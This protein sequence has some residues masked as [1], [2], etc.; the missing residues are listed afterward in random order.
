MRKPAIPPN[1]HV[2]QRIGKQTVLSAPEFV[3]SGPRGKRRWKAM[4]QCE[5]GTTRMLL[6]QS[7]LRAN[8]CG[9]DP[10]PQ[11]T[12]VTT[13]GQSRSWIYSRWRGMINRCELATH[14]KFKRYG[15]RGIKV[16]QEWHDFTTFER[17]AK[18][19]KLTRDAEIDRRDNNGDY[20]PDNCRVVTHR[21]NQ[22]NKCTSK[23]LVAFG[24]TKAA[25]EWVTDPRCRVRYQA[26]MS[27]LRYG[28]ENE[29]AIATPPMIDRSKS[30]RQ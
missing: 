11:R 13:H 5:C 7:L 22:Q 14:K 6:V 29:K 3:S 8:T 30:K 23:M 17:W 28:W 20:S 15:A 12:A 18:E 10:E 9:C 26:L 16:C 1:I 19:N 24:E 25:S 4:V 21:E 2:G 27:R